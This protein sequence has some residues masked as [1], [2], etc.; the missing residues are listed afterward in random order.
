[1]KNQPQDNTAPFTAPEIAEKFRLVSQGWTTS[2]GKP[3]TTEQRE[4]LVQKY[5]KNK[6]MK[7]ILN[8]KE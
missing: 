3:I 6:E 4:V 8:C 2:K 1:M 7:L 5:L